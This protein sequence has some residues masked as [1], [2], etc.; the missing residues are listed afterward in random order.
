MEYYAKS[1]TKSLSGDEKREIIKMIK[2]SIEI[3]EDNLT[4]SEK[5]AIN[6]SINELINTIEK[7]QVTLKQHL[8]EIVIC[9]ENFFTVYGRYFTKKEKQLV[10]EACRIHDIG[11]ANR[12]FQAKIG[13]ANLQSNETFDYEIPHGYL[14]AVSISQDELSNIIPDCTLEDFDIFITAVYH[15]HDREDKWESAKIKEF[16]KK[17]YIDNLKDYYKNE[18]K[19][20]IPA[21]ANNVLFRNNKTSSYLSLENDL[22]ERY[23]L[24]KGLLNKFD[25]TVSSGYD[26]AEVVSDIDDKILIQNIYEYFKLHNMQFNPMQV[27]MKGNIN[28]NLVVVAPTGMGKTEAAL[29]WANGEKCFYTLPYMV[30]SNAIYD[31]IKKKYN[32]SDVT[33]LHSGSMQHFIDESKI[34][35]ESAYNM[36]QKAKMLSFPLT[37]CTVDQIFKF[38]YKALG[39]EIFAA[40]LKYSK[41]IIDEIQSYDSEI[42]AAIIYGLKIISDMGGHFAIITATFPPV[43]KSLMEE[44]GLIENVD[45]EYRDFS[46]SAENKRHWL[47][48][49]YGDI[50]VNKVIEDSKNKKVLVICNTIGSSQELYRKICDI[51]NTELIEEDIEIHLLHSHFI[52]QHRR[53]L[54]EN[55]MTF[56]NNVSSVGIWIT[57]QIVEASLDID[58][59]VLY[60][61]MS[62]V[63]SLLQRLGRCN[64]HTRYIPTE[65]NIHIYITDGIDNEKDISVASYGDSV[66]QNKKRS[67]DYIYDKDIYIRSVDILKDYI[68]RTLTEREKNEYINR[69]YCTEE[70]EDTAYYK[71]IKEALNKFKNIIQLE[72]SKNDADRQFRNINSVMVIPDNIYNQNVDFIDDC[73]KIINNKYIKKDIRSIFMSKISDLTLSLPT[74]SKYKLPKM[75]DKYTINES[76]KD[77]NN[78]KKTVRYSELNIHRTSMEYEFDVEKCMGRGLLKTEENDAI[79]V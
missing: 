15:H 43:L 72:Y 18:N 76:R 55:I 4:S 78:I 17:Y 28:K 46:T 24:V 69:V 58:F 6:N 53:M 73:L 54:E 36:Y 57:T 50:D 52:K 20:I 8:E 62:T 44:Y 45:Y 35:E 2:S 27:Y 67:I 16:C 5:T 21:N 59:D 49:A 48:V 64:R 33:L 25:Y 40:T 60:T 66:S 32:Y 68:G 56:S 31:R 10:I 29:L 42:I 14:S 26:E 37:V 1:V 41:I 3:L 23:A 74:Y 30:S 70:L 65:A 12:V 38:V 34:G 71:N 9:A 13:N 77:V 7:E 22:W 63:D 61:E 51:C 11:K 47:D 39:T 75:V 19:N 79:F